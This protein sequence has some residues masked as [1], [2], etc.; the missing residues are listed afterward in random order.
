MD[1]SGTFAPSNCV[2]SWCAVAAYVFSEK[3]KSGSYAA[4]NNLKVS[5]RVSKTQEIKLKNT[6]E[7]NYFKF[8]ND[9]YDAGG[10]L[11]SVATDS[12]INSESIVNAHK[13]TQADKIRINIPLM[14]H[15]SMKQSLHEL[16]N[17]VESLPPQLYVQLLCQVDLIHD[18]LNR[19]ILYFA[20]KDPI[21]LRRFKWRIDQKDNT[22]TSY[23]SAFETIA[24]GLLQ[25]KSFKDPSISLREGDYSHMKPFLFAS[26]S[27]PKYLEKSYGIRIKSGLNVGR[28]IRADMEFPDSKADLSVQISDLLASGVRRCLRNEFDNNVRASQLLGK[29]MLSN[30]T[31][32]QPIKLIGLNTAKTFVDDEVASAVSIM[33]ESSRPI[34]L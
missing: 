19:G 18:I 14:K 10:L 26:D 3:M 1:E 32:S 24:P 33:N 8:L 28:I 12:Y 9:I 27:I 2:N 6:S 5:S 21:T 31:K 34:L 22:K 20:Q 13:K 17:R 11:F 15:Q 4:L 7:L 30:L 16:A 23:E 29:L 25:T